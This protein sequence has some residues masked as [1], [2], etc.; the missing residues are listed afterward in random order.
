M[1]WCRIMDRE[2]VEKWNRY[3]KEKKVLKD[4]DRP[5]T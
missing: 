4:G 1:S 3:I 5:R 2:Y